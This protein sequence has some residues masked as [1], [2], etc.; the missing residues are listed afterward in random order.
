MAWEYLKFFHI[1]FAF[2]LVTGVGL[3]QYGHARAM[4]TQ[5]PREFGLFLSMTRSGG[6]ITG[7]AVIVVGILGILTAWQQKWLLTDT[8]WLNISYALTIV[9][10]ILP[11]L[12]LKRW[13]EAAGKLM[14]QA[15]QQGKVLPE[16]RALIGSVKYR[17]VD[18]L[19]NALLI[20]IIIVMVFKPV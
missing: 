18:L 13:G 14:P 11:P 19:M 3:I 12:T 16:Q 15:I 6:M 10:T 7:I 20:A 4:R 8:L 5:D 17:G 9:G 1:V 2:L